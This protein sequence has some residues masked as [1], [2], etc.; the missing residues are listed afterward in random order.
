VEHS[1]G[2][3]FPP[4]AD[5]DTARVC[6]GYNRPKNGLERQ[7]RRSGAR[8]GAGGRSQ[9]ADLGGSIGA[10]LTRKAISHARLSKAL[11]M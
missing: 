1:S 11:L 7:D 2:V 8:E 4:L 9:R 5:I 3:R 10:I 6:K